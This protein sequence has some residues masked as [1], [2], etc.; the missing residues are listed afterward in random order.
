[1]ISCVCAL[2]HA[3]E[4]LCSPTNTKRKYGTPSPK[5]HPYRLVQAQATLNDLQVEYAHT[6]EAWA[7]SHASPR[8]WG[9]INT[10]IANNCS[11]LLQ[12]CGACCVP[13]HFRKHC[14]CQKA[15]RTANSSSASSSL[16]QLAWNIMLWRQWLPDPWHLQFSAFSPW[17]SLWPLPGCLGRASCH[18]WK[19]LWGC[20]KMLS[21]AMA[22]DAD[23]HPVG[24]HCSGLS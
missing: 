16:G 1:M 11:P 3:S 24:C 4:R 20:P 14:L 10:C 21:F 18:D 17:A 12:P 7:A 5:N 2:V 19:P 13:H 8:L 9:L 6:S 22:S 23:G 15:R